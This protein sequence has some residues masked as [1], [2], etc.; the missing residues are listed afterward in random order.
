MQIMQ[1]CSR[2]FRLLS[3]DEFMLRFPELSQAQK[4]PSRA[5]LGHFNFRAETKGT[6]CMSISSNF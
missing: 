4:V 2:D 6:L 5:E 3:S 1:I